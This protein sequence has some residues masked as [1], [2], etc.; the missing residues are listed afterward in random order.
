[1]GRL[2]LSCVPQLLRQ[3]TAEVTSSQG[4]WSLRKCHVTTVHEESDSESVGLSL[5]YAAVFVE[6][7]CD[8]SWSSCAEKEEE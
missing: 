7:R 5:L 4:C 2:K 1:M 6:I 8:K 3:H